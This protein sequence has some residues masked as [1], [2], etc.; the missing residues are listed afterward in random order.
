MKQNVHAFRM[1]IR[2]SSAA[3]A[4]DTFYT[5][6]MQLPL[7]R[8]VG[9]KATIWW[10]GETSVFE[11]IYVQDKVVAPEEDPAA[12][13]ALPIMR[14]VDLEATLARLGAA[15]ARTTVPERHGAGREA[16]VCDHDGYWFGLREPAADSSS[17]QD[18]NARW[19]ARR[20][21]TFNPGC[22]SMP[23]DM[24]ELGW[25]VRRAHDL[26]LM[27]RFYEET[28]G[29]TRLGEEDGRILFDAGEHVILELATG[30]V[31]RPPPKDRLDG[32]SV[33]LFRVTDIAAL[34]ASLARAG[35]HIVNERVPLHWA[36]LMY[37]ADPEGGLLGAE[38]GYHP[39]TYA[40]EKF[41]LP[42]VLEIERRRLEAAANR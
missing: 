19:R 20:G 30:G 35:T 28:L 34:R 13:A 36:D 25:I 21:E 16:F 32:S 11:A 37:F 17:P 14:V 27:S 5:D 7:L 33:A 38:Q 3:S 22:K 2:L 42:E 6:V 23:A 29:L 15:G 41:V 39:G 26:E 31:S 10:L 12:A 18:V 24:P 4:G 9:D 1:F 8:H 40:P